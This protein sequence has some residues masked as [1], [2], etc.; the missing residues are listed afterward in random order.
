MLLYVEIIIEKIELIITTNRIPNSLK[1]INRIEKGTH[2]MLGNDK[3]PAENEL[4][5]FPNP[6]NFIIPS[7]ISVPRAIEMENAATSLT[8][9]IPMLS[10]KE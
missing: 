6:L 3:R 10:G 7:P 5:V 8:S 9:V 2:A 1:P 4:N